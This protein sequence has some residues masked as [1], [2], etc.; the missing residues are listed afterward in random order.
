MFI[1]KQIFEGLGKESA[2]L[3]G[4]RQTG[5]STLLKKIYPE[6]EYFDLL[7]S[8]DYDRFLRNPSVLREILEV[9][10]ISQPVIIDEIQRI[11]FLL[12]EVQ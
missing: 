12:N 5:K 6:S 7:L 9:P 4:A 2:F 3:W 11:P 8:A 10:G 1:R